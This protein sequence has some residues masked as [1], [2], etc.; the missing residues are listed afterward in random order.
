[1]EIRCD[2][3]NGH[4]CKK[5]LAKAA[6]P[7]LTIVCPRCGSLHTVPIVVLVAELAGW[8]AEVEAQAGAANSGKGFM[9]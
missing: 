7:T 2:D 1:M 4:G 9:L 3:G 8:L 6:G 5:L